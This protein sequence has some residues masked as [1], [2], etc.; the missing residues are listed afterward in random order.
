MALVVCCATGNFTASTT[1]AQTVGANHA[2]TT[3]NI[4]LTTSNQTG[5]TFTPGAATIDGLGFRVGALAS[6]TGT[7]SVIVTLRDATAGVDKMVLTIPTADL[8]TGATGHDVE[9]GWFFARGTT[10]T[11]AA[12]NSHTISFRLN[13]TSTALSLT[14]DATAGNFQRFL[15]TTTTSSPGAGD[16]M[17]IL[18][19]WTTTGTFTQRTVTMDNTS[20]TTDYGSG[21][22][23]TGYANLPAIGIGK[24]GKLQWGTAASTNYAL[25]LSGVLKIWRGG[26]LEMSTAASP[27]DRTSTYRLLFDTTNNTYAYGI[28]VAEGGSFVCHGQS[29]TAGNSTVRATLSGDVTNG[30]VIPLD[31]ATGWKNGDEVIIGA[32]QRSAASIIRTLS[33][34][35]LSTSV[36]VGSATGAGVTFHGTGNAKAH[37]GLITR[38]IMI[39]NVWSTTYA[40]SGLSASYTGSPVNGTFSVSWTEFSNHAITQQGAA[41]TLA[42]AIT[43]DNCSWRMGSQTISP[44]NIG[45]EANYVITNPI[46]WTGTG[47][48]GGA[49]TMASANVLN[50]VKCNNGLFCSGTNNQGYGLYYVMSA[51]G[52]GVNTDAMA[53]NWFHSFASGFYV[54]CTF[55]FG[56]TAS[57][58]SGTEFINCTTPLNFASTFVRDCEFANIKAHRGNGTGI[59]NA[60]GSA[61]R[62]VFSNIDIFGQATMTAFSGSGQG[63]SNVVYRRVRGGAEGS[64]F[65]DYGINF[66]TAANAAGFINVTYQSCEFGTPAACSTADLRFVSVAANTD[67]AVRQLTFDSCSFYSATQTSAATNATITGESFIAFQGVGTAN[68]RLIPNRGSIMQNTTT[69][70]TAPPSEEIQPVCTT[71]MFTTMESGSKRVAVES[72]TTVTM[73]VYVRKDAVYN[74]QAPLLKV[75]N[76]YS[77]GVL[78]A[79]LATHTAG[80]NTWQQLIGTT[81]TVT[82]DGVLDFFVEVSGTTGSVFIDDWAAS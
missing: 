37:I 24:F 39:D 33:A 67:V 44:I 77:M 25:K 6:N 73:S 12:G 74:G 65:T 45:G 47:L 36:T 61:H 58:H 10:T 19:E 22:V 80:A 42:T 66:A 49:W 13:S 79:V 69:Y 30:T 18:G 50:N 78:E 32:S 41:R 64:A 63:L 43:L 26:E 52:V 60:N 56:I 40:A 2:V 7:N 14:R 20:V 1:W 5:S 48:S 16:E 55:I 21:P 29:R 46:I 81:D 4:G 34:D 23:A 15:R 35:A 38:N 28:W 53:N 62:L 51:S 54:F 70:N 11:L 72:G 59:W 17:Y 82:A 57:Q 27:L 68:R 3:A 8:P 31:T 9:G 75:R 71:N 76:N